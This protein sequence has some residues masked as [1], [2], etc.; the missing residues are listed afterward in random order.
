[1]SII[2]ENLRISFDENILV[3]ELNFKI[4]NG[5][6]AIVVGESG[7]G[8][9]SLL[10]VI[11]GLKKPDCGS[12]KL[13]GKL[14]YDSQLNLDPHERNIGYVFQD[15][16]LFPHINA[17][18]N[19]RFSEN[20]N[21]KKMFDIYTVELKLKKHL[22]KMP[23]EL[24]GGQQQ[25]VS[26]ARA[27]MMSPE[28]LILDEPLSNLDKQTALGAQNLIKEYIEMFNIPCLIVTHDTDQINS[29][30]ISHTIKI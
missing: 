10:N 2:V 8:K 1:M 5:E 16:A 17:E 3:S 12:I 19:I 20:S 21:S 30:N 6:V 29:L 28:L 18:K 14:I 9:S 26:I 4:K 13:N 11:A 15:F 22:T 25:R 7:A 27:L 24:S 23:H